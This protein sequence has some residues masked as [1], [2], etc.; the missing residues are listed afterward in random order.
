VRFRAILFDAGETLVHPT[1]SFPERFSEVLATEGHPCAPEEVVEASKAVFHRFSEAARNGELWTTSPQRSARFWNDVYDRMLASLGL[2]GQDG[3][4]DRLYATFTDLAS[5][6]L[7][8]DVLP[9]LDALRP[10]GA[11]LGIVSN[12]EA[13]LEDLLERLGVRDRFPVRVIS[14]V[15][16]VEK[17]DERIYRLALERAEA[18][19]EEAVYVGDNPEF[20][21]WPAAALGMTPVLIDRRGRFPDHEGLRITDLRHLPAVLEDAS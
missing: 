5:Y 11:L 1:P 6:G 20:D 7:F 8:E 16:G 21:V 18:R 15:V 12:Y 2:P 9:T 17:P 4:R 13:W 14:G 19:A 3:I 10:G